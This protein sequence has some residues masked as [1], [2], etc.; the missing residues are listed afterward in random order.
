[1]KRL[2]LAS[3]SPRR[4]E[5]LSYALLLF[6]VCPS[7]IEE[8]MDPGLSAEE[9]VCSLAEQKA[10]DIF[11]QHPDAVIAG[12]D[13]IVVLDGKPLGKPKDKQEARDMLQMLSGRTHEVYTGVCLIDSDRSSVFAEKTEVRFWPLTAEEIEWYISTKEPFDKAGAYGI[14]GKGAVFV[15]SI[16]GD[17]Y[18]VMGLPISRVVRELEGFGIFRHLGQS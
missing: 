9:L 4:K 2:I 6:D 8:V 13:T 7:K 12:S 11:S 14:Q 1:M 10:R 15:H 16:T 17:Y 18:N 5:L 3:S